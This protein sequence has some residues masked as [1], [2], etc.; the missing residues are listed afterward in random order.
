MSRPSGE[1]FQL[2]IRDSGRDGDSP[3]AVRLRIL[4]KRLLR[5]LGFRCE[6]IEP[7]APADAAPIEPTSA[8]A[9]PS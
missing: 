4:L 2:V 1:R 7:A 9:P 8:D 5:G 6:K 3:T